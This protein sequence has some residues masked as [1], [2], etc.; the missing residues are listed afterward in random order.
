MGGQCRCRSDRELRS[1][2]DLSRRSS[3]W[4]NRIGRLTRARPL[5]ESR[6]ISPGTARTKA[7]EDFEDQNL[8]GYHVGRIDCV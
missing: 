7:A 5:V 8:I 3:G 6:S 2:D 4:I 1:A